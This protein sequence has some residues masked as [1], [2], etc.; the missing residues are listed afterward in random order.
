MQRFRAACDSFPV[1]KSGGGGRA[2]GKQ[3]VV[4]LLFV[5]AVLVAG[6]LSPR[7]GY[8]VK[9]VGAPASVALFSSMEP[10]ASIRK[11]QDYVSGEIW[12]MLYESDLEEVLGRISVET[13]QRTLDIAFAENARKATDLFA[14]RLSDVLKTRDDPPYMLALTIDEWGLIAA[15]EDEENGPYILLTMQLI[16]RETNSSIWKYSR[17]FQQPVDRDADAPRRPEMLEDAY[18]HLITRAVDAYFMWLG[19]E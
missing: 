17:L 13:L 16:D 15:K 3:K 10:K 4:S 6:C 14:P 1:L 12:N 5:T 19:D 8:P 2:R 11:D 9:T 7:L 18:A